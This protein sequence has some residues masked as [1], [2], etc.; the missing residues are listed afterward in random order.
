[1]AL[2]FQHMIALDCLVARCA[3]RNDGDIRQSV[4]ARSEATKQSS[5][6]R[7]CGYLSS[8]STALPAAFESAPFPRFQNPHC[9]TRRAGI[10]VSRNRLR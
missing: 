10:A 7:D 3:P 1:M 5:L 2:S 4:I 6:G 8:S 9:G